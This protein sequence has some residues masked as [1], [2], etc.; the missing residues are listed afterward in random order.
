MRMRYNDSEK[1]C[2]VSTWCFKMISITT[3]KYTGILHERFYSNTCPRVTP[4]NMQI[5]KTLT[6]RPRYQNNFGTGIIPPLP[7]RHT[8]TGSSSYPRVI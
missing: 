4:L 3:H 8:Y 1:F 6:N 2:H 7:T 5:L